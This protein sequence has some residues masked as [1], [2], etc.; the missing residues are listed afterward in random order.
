MAVFCPSSQNPA[1]TTPHIITP[2]LS[3]GYKGSYSPNA[4]ARLLSQPS[5]AKTI[6]CVLHEREAT[7]HYQT[8]NSEIIL[9]TVPFYN[10]YS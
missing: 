6:E 1:S 3:E 4:A 5:P 10:R 8:K 9:K 2:R 7:L